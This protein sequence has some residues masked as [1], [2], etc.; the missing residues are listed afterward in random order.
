[1]LTAFRLLLIA[2]ATFL[3]SASVAQDKIVIAYPSRSIASID[4]YIAQER[5][6]FRQENLAADVV[7]VRGNIAVTALLSGETHAINNVGTLTRAMQR[8]DLPT[9]VVAQSLKKNMF[10]LVTKPDIKS[11]SEMKGKIFGITT[12]GGSQHSS[13]NRHLLKAGL[14]PDK[15]V[16]VIIGGDVPAQLQ[17]LL[18]GVI[19]LAALSPPTVILARDKFKLKLHANTLDDAAN[20]QNGLAVSEKLLRERRDLVKRMLRARARGARYLF[21]NERGAAEVLAK[22]L[23][24]DMSV[25]LE[26]Y[27]LAKP[28]FTTN[29]IPTDK[30]VEEFLRSEAELLKL[31]QPVSPAKIYDFSLQR[32]VNQELGIK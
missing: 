29:S 27:H 4:L 23:G 8:S 28:A 22:Y 11:L 14:D 19:H 24:V 18:S 21:E 10:W 9:K 5:G 16:T 2:L 20:L 26:S 17:S 7:Q 30:E 25:A 15:D 1:M 6:F 3:S 12:F 13:A 32:E 31:P